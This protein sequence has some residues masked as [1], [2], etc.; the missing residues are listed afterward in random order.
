MTA[1]IRPSVWNEFRGTP[2]TLFSSADGPVPFQSNIGGA[3]FELNAGIDAMITDGTSLFANAGYQVGIN[4][5]N[6][7]A[8]N[9]KIGLRMAW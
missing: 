4:N 9:G 7:T 6:T 1:W 3:W 8:Y 5:N 2:Q